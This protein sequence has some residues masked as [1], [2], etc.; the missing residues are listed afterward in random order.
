VPLKGAQV[1]VPLKG[2][3]AAVPLKGARKSHHKGLLNSEHRAPKMKRGTAAYRSPSSENVRTSKKLSQILRHTAEQLGLVMRSDGYTKVHDLLLVYDGQ[4]RVFP[5]LTVSDLRRLVDENDK[6]RFGLAQDYN[7]NLLIRACQGHSGTTGKGI[8]DDLLLTYIPEIRLAIPPGCT[9]IHGTTKKAWELIAVSGIRSMG[10]NHIHLSFH[11][12]QL[13]WSS[14]D[15]TNKSEVRIHLDSSAMAAEGMRFLQSDNGVLLTKGHGHADQV[16]GVIDH[17]FFV[18]V[19]Q[20]DPQAT[21]WLGGRVVSTQLQMVAPLSLPVHSRKACTLVASRSFKARMQTVEESPSRSPSPAPESWMISPSRP[22]RW[23]WSD[24]EEEWQW[25]WQERLRAPTPPS[26][27]RSESDDAGW[28]PIQTTYWERTTTWTYPRGEDQSW[29]AS[30]NHWWYT[31]QERGPED[32]YA[33]QTVVWKEVST[34][35]TQPSRPPTQSGQQEETIPGTT[36]GDPYQT[37]RPG[38]LPAAREVIS[39]PPG[40]GPG[41]TGGTWPTP[42]VSAYDGTLSKALAQIL[43]HEAPSMDADG[44]TNIREVQQNLWRRAS[45]EEIQAVA[46]GSRNKDDRPRFQLDHTG[47]KIKAVFFT[48]RRRSHSRRTRH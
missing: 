4:K 31:N 5:H 42:T 25:N 27:S 7:G 47:L 11:K 37:S 32:W 20:K 28:R 18:N 41:S 16:G 44:Y 9:V 23:L 21:L 12:T 36:T 22:W 33:R 45:L 19:Y 17:R 15:L 3:Q 29:N 34:I 6:Q 30:E 26:S 46:R 8:R 24:E 14:P 35:T 2:V 48:D 43:R 10:R 39:A 13:G 1:A 40:L 38:E